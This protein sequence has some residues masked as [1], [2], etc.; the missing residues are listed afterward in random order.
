MGFAQRLLY[1]ALNATWGASLGTCAALLA[2]QVGAW[3]DHHPSSGLLLAGCLSIFGA[4]Y[5]ATVIGRGQRPTLRGGVIVAGYGGGGLRRLGARGDGARMVDGV[6]RGGARRLRLRPAA[7]A[8]AVRTLARLGTLFACCLWGAI[9][10]WAVALAAARPEPPP[11]PRRCSP[12]ERS[13]CSA[14]ATC[15]GAGSAAA[16]RACSCSGPRRSPRAPRWPRRRSCP[17]WPRG[18]RSS[19]RPSSSGSSA[20]SCGPTRGGSGILRASGQEAVL[21]GRE[22]R[23]GRGRSATGLSAAACSPRALSPRARSSSPARPSSSRT[24]T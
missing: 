11:G 7:A 6:D 19:S 17:G 23:V 5:V 1:P 14:A 18:S 15:W 12:T 13:R 20:G 21:R 9:A 24:P 22:Q 16:R 4:A 8:A 3:S 10:G 2:Y